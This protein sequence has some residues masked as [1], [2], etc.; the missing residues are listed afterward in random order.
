MERTKELKEVEGKP[1]EV[2][3]KIKQWENL[4]NDIREAKQDFSNLVRNEAMVEA[5]HRE[6]QQAFTRISQLAVQAHATADSYRVAAIQARHLVKLSRSQAEQVRNEVTTGN[7]ATI[8]AA[9]SQ[10]CL[11]QSQLNG[12]TASRDH[13][14]GD[15]HNAPVP[16]F[17][18]IPQPR[19]DGIAKQ[20]CNTTVFASIQV[21][22]ATV[23]FLLR[24]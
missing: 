3:Q 7:L 22:E 2:V 20:Q 23:S 9:E 14:I 19:A 13:L 4:D 17:L 6:L 15:L 16:G 12:V 21:Q 8:W 5:R 24:S 1:A 18:R 10:R 11:L